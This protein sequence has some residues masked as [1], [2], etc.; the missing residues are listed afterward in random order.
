MPAEQDHYDVLELPRKATAAEIK[1]RYRQLMR[2]AHPDANQNDPRATRRAARINLAYETL[3]N[4]SRRAEYD[5]RTKTSVNGASTRRER[6][7]NDKVYAHWAQQENWEDIVAESVPPARPKH[8][9]TEEPSVDPDEIEVSIDE[10]ESVRRVK[11]RIM[12]RN[13]CECTL[14]GEVATSEPWL[15]GPVGTFEVKPGGELAFDVEVVSSKVKF[16][17]VS[18][19]V[20]VSPAWTGT[21]PVR[22][23]GWRAKP[24]KVLPS[25]PGRYV[26]GSART[27]RWGRIVR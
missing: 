16:P 21:V 25:S 4:A 7:H 22:V 18:R 23:T 1:S 8:M 13:P 9:H 15:W 3:G 26:R 6:A 19:V 14:K 20:F 17:G 5:A 27:K 12:V 24:R 11:R 10:L 2:E